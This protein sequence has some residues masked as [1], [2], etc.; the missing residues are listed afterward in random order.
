MKSDESEFESEDY[1]D[2]DE[3]QDNDDYEMIDDG[4][5]V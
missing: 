3:D 4:V 2:D 1:A 5:S